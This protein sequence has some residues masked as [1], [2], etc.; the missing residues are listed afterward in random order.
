M[1]EA[2]RKDLDRKDGN[3]RLPDTELEVMQALWQAGLWLPC[4][5]WEVYYEQ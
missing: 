4:G 5:L 1:K 3:R 2:S